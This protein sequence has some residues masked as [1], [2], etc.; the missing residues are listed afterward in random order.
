MAG[1]NGPP[2]F[3]GGV[4]HVDAE[5]GGGDHQ[6]KV[7][8]A[9]KDSGMKRGEKPKL[10]VL[11]IFLERKDDTVSFKLSKDDLAKLLFKKM[12]LESVEVL[13]IDTSGYGK[14]HLERINLFRWRI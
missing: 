13:K 8:Y 1:P 11:D 14:I 6:N 10:N 2:S 12:K 9:N 3:S 4:P 5:V 7:T